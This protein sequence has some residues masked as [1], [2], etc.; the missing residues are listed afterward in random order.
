MSEKVKVTTGSDNIFRDLGFP[1]PE[2]HLAKAHLALAI[3]HAI[4]A[5]G[6]TQAEYCCRDCG[7][8]LNADLNAARNIGAMATG[9]VPAADGSVAPRMAPGEPRFVQAKL[10]AS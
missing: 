6:L 8:R 10:S 5:Q 4:E 3:T 1:N 2:E 7:L 9:H